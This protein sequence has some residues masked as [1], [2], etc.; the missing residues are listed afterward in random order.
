MS[1]DRVAYV[2]QSLAS[3]AL[4]SVSSYSKRRVIR[5]DAIYLGRPS[6]SPRWPAPASREPRLLFAGQSVGA[7]V[8]ADLIEAGA[9]HE[10]TPALEVVERAV[11]G[12]L[13]AS[14]PHGQN[15]EGWRGRHVICIEQ[16]P[17]SRRTSSHVSPPSG[18]EL[19]SEPWR[20]A[21]ISTT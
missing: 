18:A 14:N 8:V 10:R 16:L 12:V 3:A 15:E 13:F 2:P 7:V 11:A 17:T 9:D 21:W 20:I 5:K 4:A 1:G 19:F 6:V